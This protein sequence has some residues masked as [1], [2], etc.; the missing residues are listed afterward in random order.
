V[1]SAAPKPLVENDPT[2]YPIRDDMGEGSLQRFISELLRPLLAR[3]LA[4]QGVRAFVG[5]DQFIY[6]EQHAPTKS[7][8]P[9]VYVMPGVDQDIAPDCWKIWEAGVVPSFAF[10]VVSRDHRKDTDRSPVRYDELGVKELVVFDPR[11]EEAGKDRVQWKVFRRVAKRGLVLV[12]ATNADRIRSKVLRC[13]L[14]AVGSGPNIRVR[15]ATGPTGDELVL[16]ER[17]IAKR[18]REEAERE[19]KAREQAEA[20]LVQMRAELA[21]LRQK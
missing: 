15:V 9:D 2:F 18:A 21:R 1:V 17:E 11:F 8:S 10:E 16:T 20:E 3:F 19:R 6:W 13:W 14:R 5:A 12:E 7:V 4:E